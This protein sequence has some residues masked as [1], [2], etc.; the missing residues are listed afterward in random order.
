MPENPSDFIEVGGQRFSRDVSPEQIAFILNQTGASPAVAHG[1]GMLTASGTPA[2]YPLSQAPSVSVPEGAPL[3]PSHYKTDAEAAAEVLLGMVPIGAGGVGVAGGELAALKGIQWMRASGMSGPMADFTMR[4]LPIMGRTSG[5]YVGGYAGSRASSSI[6]QL[7]GME[8]APKTPQEAEQRAREAGRSQAKFQLVFE[9]GVPLAKNYIEGLPA[10]AEK[11]RVGRL[12]K[13]QDEL[14]I[15]AANRTMELA[16]GEQEQAVAAELRDMA[17]EM[18][19]SIGPKKGPGTLKLFSESIS[20]KFEAII[21]KRSDV[22][23]KI[24]DELALKRP[25][26]L[27]SRPL[28]RTLLKLEAA[29]P[30][31]PGSLP[32]K[33]TEPEARHLELIEAARSG[34]VRKVV[35]GEKTYG[36][37]ATT[38]IEKVGETTE[39]VLGVGPP[40]DTALASKI[41][42]T[43][44]WQ[45]DELSQALSYA[46]AP[47][48][49][50]P[51]AVLLKGRG[52]ASRE[53]AALMQNPKANQ[54]TI[55][56]LNIII[57][58]F[59]GM[60]EQ[61]LARISDK[62]P[63]IFRTAKR[64]YSEGEVAKRMA[65]NEAMKNNPSVII[66]YLEPN[67]PQTVRQ[68]DTMLKETGRESWRP[69]I[70]RAKMDELLRSSQ[71][72]FDLVNFRKRYEEYGSTARALI[73]LAREQGEGQVPTRNLG[74]VQSP[75]R[76]AKPQDRRPDG[77][78][79][80]CDGDPGGETGREGADKEDH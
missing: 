7:A 31:A 17:N 65:L 68:L 41:Q 42:Y 53:R 33:F 12:A 57:E 45:A 32:G 30:R 23:Y 76:Q 52:A 47:N 44:E 26:A 79:L 61:G 40:K 34:N 62:A 4:A 19:A 54:E 48:E 6:E 10:K 78:D 77:A 22:L 13:E 80:Q 21:E 15:A 5:A 38:K 29:E 73:Q 20:K 49:K 55:R 50:I 46:S 24:L 18:V 8:S 60:I 58:D 2:P 51:L 27:D 3:T 37:S 9:A 72:E 39:P 56:D 1:P 63:T 59:D 35:P 36:G 69:S 70:E 74:R 43:N 16:K 14:D 75:R 25:Q 71:G 28:A 67:A 11:S 64:L 66:D